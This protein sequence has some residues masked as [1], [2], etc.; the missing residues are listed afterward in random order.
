MLFEPAARSSIEPQPSP[1]QPAP[2]VAFGDLPRLSAW[3]YLGMFTGFLMVLAITVV[4]ARGRIFWED[5]MLGWLLLRDPSWHHMIRAWNLGA[6]GG[7]FSFYLLGRAWFRVFGDSALAFRLFSSTCFGVAFVATWAALRRFYPIWIVAFAAANTFFFSP[8]LTT[9]FLE[10]RFYGLLVM[11]TA[12]ALWLALA[13]DEAP[14]ATPKYLY[15]AAFLI[16]GLLTTSHVLGVVFSVAVLGATVVLDR[17]R[18]RLRIGL[19]AT[20]AASWLLLLPEK[21]SILAAGRVGKPHFWTK[22]PTLLE[23]VGAWSGFSSEI[24]LV[25]LGL[26]LLAVLTLLRGRGGFIKE[27]RDSFTQRWPVYVVSAC[28]LL[29][30]LAFLVEGLT[31][32]WLFTDRYLQPVTLGLAY[33]TAELAMIVRASSFLVSMKQRRPGITGVGFAFAALVFAG[34][35]FVWVF[36]HVAQNTPEAM[37]FTDQLTAHLPHD[38]PVVA[39][40]AFTFTD[41]M[42]RQAQSG[43]QYTFLLDWPWSLNAAA[44]RVEVTQ[45]HLME[46][47]KRAGYYAGHIQDA[48]AFLREHDRFLVVHSG[49]IDPGPD[50]PK[51][52]IGNPLAERLAGDPRYEV[53]KYFTLDRVKRD[54]ARDTVWLVCRGSCGGALPAQPDRCVLSPRGTDCCAE[55]ACRLPEAAAPERFWH[56]RSWW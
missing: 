4:N 32:T 7:G 14:E 42:G 6:D 9:H 49:P 39:E 53:R 37:D 47:W 45:F 50:A 20:I 13:L 31:G 33:V 19:Y 24:R 18:G 52:E 15:V 28:L 36:H 2:I 5:E 38:L 30:P 51:P 46:N 22:A 41:L 27:L 44:P 55:H 12:F 35:T 16:H 25:L 3:D 29:V 1:S 23:L 10:G 11:S 48:A 8:P 43:V 40:D 34:C 56:V 26:G 21:T 17:M 54:S